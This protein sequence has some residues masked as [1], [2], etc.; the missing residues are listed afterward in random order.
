[1]F[2]HK[3]D[4]TTLQAAPLLVGALEGLERQVQPILCPRQL[5]ATPFGRE[6]APYGR[7][8]VQEVRDRSEGLVVA[9]VDVDPQ[10]LVLA[11]LRGVDVAEVDSSVVAVRVE[12]PDGGAAQLTRASN[13]AAITAT[14]AVRYW[15]T[16]IA[17][18]DAGSS[19]SIANGW[20]VL[21]VSIDVWILGS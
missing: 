12:Q 3:V 1:V 4:L 2:R 11:E 18:S 6:S 5:G 13:A 10:Q 8:Q 9:T 19:S 15:R 20:R 21:S 17:R 7:R 14:T 16:S